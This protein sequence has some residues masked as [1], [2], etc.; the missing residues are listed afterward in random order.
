M[1]EP[2]YITSKDGTRLRVWGR[3]SYPGHYDLSVD[4]VDADNNIIKEYNDKD[5]DH[6]KYFKYNEHP[7]D[8]SDLATKETAVITK[9]EAG[10][11]IKPAM[12]VGGK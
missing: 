4:V 11:E 9:A 3:L 12:I 5:T 8:D 7:K 1:A 2:K 10:T 6:V